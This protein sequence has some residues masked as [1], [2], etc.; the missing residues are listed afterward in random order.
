MTPEERRISFLHG[1]LTNCWNNLNH[2]LR[3]VG[4]PECAR[5]ISEAYEAV[6]KAK[7][8][9]ERMVNEATVWNDEGQDDK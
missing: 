1:I 5:L 7:E 9:N 4:D 8:Y 6:E 2:A 3:L